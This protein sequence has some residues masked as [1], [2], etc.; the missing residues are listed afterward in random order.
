MVGWMIII[1]SVF[2][3]INVFDLLSGLRSLET[4]ETVQDYLS[5]APGDQLGWSVEDGLSALRITA[6]VT[7]VCAVVAAV[8]GWH[9]LRRHH[10]ARIGLTVVAVPLFVT[11][12]VTGGF[13]SSLVAAAIVL[14]WMQPARDWFNGVAARP[15]PPLNREDGARNPFDRPS[16]R[17]TDRQGDQPGGEPGG[18]PSDRPSADAPAPP[19]VKVPVG[20]PPHGDG[21]RPVDGFGDQPGW[22]PPAPAPGAEQ[23]S[24]PSGPYGQPTGQPYGHAAGQ[25]YGAPGQPVAPAHQGD[26][27]TQYGPQ[28]GVHPHAPRPAASRRPGA[29]VLA[30]VVTWIFAGFSLVSAVATSVLL[31]LSPGDLEAEMEKVLADFEQ[32]GGREITTDMLMTTTIVMGAVMALFCLVACLAALLMLGRRPQAAILLVITASFSAFFCLVG[33]VA[34]ASPLLLVPG[35]ASVVVLVLLRRRDVR[36]WLAGR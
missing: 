5:Q 9:V 23:P 4:R 14:L 7:A 19:R 29:I 34:A 11:G 15:T 28:Y 13:I 24:A 6:M 36:E 2:V 20:G 31:A 17:P 26:P 27:N 25:P 12:V 1:G 35:A 10:A 8:L 22:A 3:V 16:A 32:S 21:A 30:A 18:G 33:G